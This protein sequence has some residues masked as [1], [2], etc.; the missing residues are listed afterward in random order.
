MI[1]WTPRVTPERLVWF[2][3][4]IGPD[5]LNE[6]T[7]E[8]EA[9]EEQKAGKQTCTPLLRHQQD[10]VSEPNGLATLERGIHISDQDRNTRKETSL[11]SAMVI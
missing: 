10:I 11:R 1:A 3:Y 2:P 5:G 8:R 4:K 7:S 9:K 6:T